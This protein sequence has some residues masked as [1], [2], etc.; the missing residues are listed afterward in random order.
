M[1]LAAT[2]LYINWHSVSAL[3][4]T[5]SAVPV[6]KVTSVA[7]EFSGEMEKFKGDA[8]RFW[9]AIA[10]PSQTR[11]LEITT[12]DVGVSLALVVGA[13]YTVSAVLDDAI[14]GS[15]VGGGG[16]TVTLINAVFG[17]P[18]IKGD[19][20]KFNEVTLTFESF[21]GAADADPLTVVPL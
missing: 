17:G 18:K 6:N 20:A 8:H 13:V 11:M 19:H 12:G 7:P 2:H 15:A 4:A 16:I 9:D 21:G 5:G 3:P 14:N 1:T 10:V